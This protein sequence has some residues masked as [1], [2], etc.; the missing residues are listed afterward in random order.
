MDRS[1]T[2]NVSRY[3]ST[4]RHTRLL[5]FPLLDYHA[6]KFYFDH[7]GLEKELYLLLGFSTT[8]VASYI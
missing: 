1:V 3:P 7:R 8:T 5:L 2:I 6:V 4:Y